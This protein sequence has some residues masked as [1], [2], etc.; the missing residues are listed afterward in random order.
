MSSGALKLLTVMIPL[1]FLIAIVGLRDWLFGGQLNLSLEVIAVMIVVLISAGFSA[2]IFRL[3]QKREAEIGQRS[4]QLT[5]LHQA[6]LTLTTEL[7]LSVVLQ[8]VAELARGLI[9]AKYGALGMLGETGDYLE[10]FIT[11]GITPEERA[12]VGKPPS[13]RGLLGVMIREG[14]PIRVSNIADDPRAVGL[15]P[16]HPPIYSLLGVPVHSKGKVIG[17]LYLANKL[18]R[19]S[20]DGREYCEFTER[21]QEVLEMFATQASI[22]IENAQLYRQTQQL[23]IFQER[24]RFGMD[25]HDGVIQSLYAIGLMLDDTR[26]NLPYRAV[27][28]KERIAQALQGLNEVIR[29]IRNYILNLRPERF[30]G[31]DL[32]CGLI[33]L[34]RDLR[35]NSF[36]STHL[37]LDG[38]QSEVLNPEHTVE[39]LH[40]AQEA[41][42]NVRKHARACNVFIKV[43]QQDH[44]LVLSI[45]DD[46][47]GMRGEQMRVG[48][49]GL[50]NMQLRAEGLGG[51]LDISPRP[52]GGTCV[53]LRFPLHHQ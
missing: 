48:G 41:L 17:D 14:K 15:P 20:R 9:G 23:A 11:S 32:R 21:D 43:A 26:H 13:G 52:D 37:E 10:Q 33:E 49:Q 53:T 51:D 47:I 4:E 25:L 50:I 27:E 16:N 39:V 29:D 5:A 8:K 34:E 36:L 24:E 18:P 28:E 40:I 35:A 22:A 45:S 3:A 46:G 19:N 44:I 6:A 12:R 42:T 38:L 30:Q 1:S 31:N 2:V 7:E